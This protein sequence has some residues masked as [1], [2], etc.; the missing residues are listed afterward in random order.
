MS[1]GGGGGGVVVSGAVTGSEV[2]SVIGGRIGPVGGGVI[3]SDAGA[4]GGV[5]V[6][7]WVVSGGGEVRRGAESEAPD[8]P[9][10][11]VP[12]ERMITS[13]LLSIPSAL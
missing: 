2:V 5:V 10:G 9:V 4:G 8:P 1:F 6:A 7:V 3:V 13:P 11:T 12:T